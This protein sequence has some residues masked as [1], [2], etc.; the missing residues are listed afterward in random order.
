MEGAL[1]QEASA[2]L[3]EIYSNP[4]HASAFS[5]PQQ[6]YRYV[7]RD[8]KF[9]LNLKVINKW[10][11][12][13][14]VYTT[15]RKITRKIRRRRVIAPY[16]DFMW[17]IDTANFQKLTKSN[18]GY[19]YFIL[20][21]DVMSR[22][23]WTCPIK[24]TTG[25]E[26]SRALEEI[27][28]QK[29]VPLKIRTDK[30]TEFSNKTVKSVFKS[31]SIH[32]FVTQ[33]ET[34]AN[35]AERC[36]QTI[37]SKLTRYMRSKQSHKWVDVLADV[38]SGYNN[39]FHRS[40]SKAP[41]Q[42]NKQDENRMWDD[43]VDSVSKFPTKQVPYKFKIGD[44]VRISK[45]R[46]SFHR[47]YSEHWTNEFFVISERSF[48]QYT[49]AYTLTDYAGELISGIFYEAELQKIVV[50]EDTVY[51]IEKVVKRRKVNNVKQVLVKWWGWPDKFDSWIPEAD[52]TNF[53]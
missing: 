24:R 23:V 33:N 10:L 7:K 19:G 8:G 13:Q 5:S 31:R 18:S 44:V 1:T 21:I 12:S 50:A 2:Y 28:K 17:D 3:K 46:H 6:L 11:Q 36:I 20:A 53:T 25:A 52:M 16:I 34:K 9:R 32:H 48:K 27:F 39:S 38:T 14:E 30:G 41:A 45:L 42:F 40:I 51:N 29:R 15:N 47:Y 4:K 37:K 35:Y 43:L 49:P 22:Y 26:V